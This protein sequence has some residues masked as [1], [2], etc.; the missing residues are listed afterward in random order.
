MEDKRIEEQMPRDNTQATPPGIARMLPRGGVKS[1]EAGSF[2]G[3]QDGVQ[4]EVGLRIG[5]TGPGSAAGGIGLLL[6]RIDRLGHA[7]DAVLVGADERGAGPIDVAVVEQN[8]LAI[9]LVIAA[10]DLPQLG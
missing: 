8:V 2:R 3:D 9:L 1:W 10:V 4:V 7:V 5:Q 6:R